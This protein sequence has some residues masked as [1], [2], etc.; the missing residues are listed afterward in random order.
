MQPKFTIWLALLCYAFIGTAQTNWTGNTSTDWFEPTNWDNGVPAAGNQP[1][2]I[3]NMFP[4]AFSP[5]INAA[6]PPYTIDYDVVINNSL[7][8]VTETNIAGQIVIG[9]SGTFAVNGQFISVQAGGSILNGGGLSFNSPEESFND[10]VITNNGGWVINAGSFLRNQGSGTMSNN[11]FFQIFGT[12]NNYATFNNNGTTQVIA[13]GVL[14]NRAAGSFNNNVG[15]GLQVFGDF[16]TRGA[17]VNDGNISNQGLLQLLASGTLTNNNTFQNVVGSTLAVLG[18]G[19]LTNYGNIAADGQ[20]NVDLNARIS[21]NSVFNV[22][23]NGAV[24][25]SGTILNFASWSLSGSFTNIGAVFNHDSWTNDFGSTF[26]N[27]GG[28][29]SNQSCDY[30][31][32]YTANPLNAGTVENFGIIYA[33]GSPVN[34]T[35]GNGAYFTN[36][37]NNPAP[38]ANCAAPF[39]INLDA[40]NSASITPA[41][42][43]NGSSAPYCGIA[44]MTISQSDFDCSDIGQNTVVLT[45]TD[46]LGY[47]SQC[48]TVV[49]IIDP[50]APQITCPANITQGND[51]GLCGATIIYTP[52]VGTDNCPNPTTS[53]TAGIGSGGFFPVGTTT[54]TYTV[55][56]TYGNTASCSFTVTINDVEDPVINCPAD[57][58]VE[59]LPF[60]CTAVVDY[61]VTA[62]D[63]CTVLPFITQTDTS[64]YTSGSEFLIG[65]TL[66]SYQAIDG[67]GNTDE[68]S[69]SITVNE[70]QALGN[71]LAC[72]DNA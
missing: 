45:V 72:N 17:T 39:S 65:T 12:L 33:I 69:F 30:L 49:T 25:N 35:G 70:F 64:G 71:T 48:Q 42:I 28:I 29:F 59:L 44:S 51:P 27:N 36:I 63:N 67:A 53:I 3:P 2:T 47:S 9:G 34:V 14:I 56:D 6:F 19:M 46:S 62:T 5:I 66:Q 38:N 4:G 54:E 10:G 22:F 18:T 50:F 31:Y 52:P 60:E 23:S 1:A 58:I 11:S 20:L 37:N 24:N 61:M 13:G 26:N 68:C 41:D 57:I 8:I 7:Q 55:T 43:D 21:N 16:Q 15:S 40:M 32:H